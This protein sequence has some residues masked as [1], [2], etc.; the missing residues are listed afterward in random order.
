[1]YSQW[2]S[3]IP[4]PDTR[5]QPSETFNRIGKE[6]PSGPG[7]KRCHP[8]IWTKTADDILPYTRRQPTSDAGH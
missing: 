1:L 3:T 7:T 4:L 2:L 8:F 6:M 5:P